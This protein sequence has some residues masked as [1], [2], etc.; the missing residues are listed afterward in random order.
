MKYVDLYDILPNLKINFQKYWESEESIITPAL[1]SAGYTLNSW[2]TGEGDSFGPLS[3]CI[4]AVDPNG[5]N[6]IIIYG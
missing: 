1:K 4:R 5:D 2:Y 6:I 3:R